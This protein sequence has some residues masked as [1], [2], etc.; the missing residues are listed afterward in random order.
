MCATMSMYA[1]KRCT[2]L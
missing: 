2:R 1:Y